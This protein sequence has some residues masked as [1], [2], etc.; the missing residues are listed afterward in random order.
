MFMT[1]S[2]NHDSILLEWTQAGAVGSWA[3]RG[4]DC[5][6]KFLFSAA[7]VYLSMIFHPP[8]IPTYRKDCSSKTIELHM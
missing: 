3:A 2:D 8:I 7:L 1:E 6:S 4:I 5:A